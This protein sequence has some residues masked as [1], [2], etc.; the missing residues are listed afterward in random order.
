M[1]GIIGG[2]GL[3]SMES[4]GK[5][6][7][8]RV[9]TEY[10]S[11]SVLAEMIEHENGRFVFLARHGKNHQ[12]APHE[13]NYRANISALKQLGV[14]EIIA[15]NAVG[16][17]T[18]NTI[19]GAIIIPDQLIDYT[20]GR[21]STFFEGDANE[22]HHIDFTHPFDAA[23]SQR[24]LSAVEASNREEH[25]RRMV[26]ARAVYGVTQGP[27]L[28]TAAEINRMKR[29]GCDIVGMTAM[30][31]AALARE[32][33][34]GYAMVALSVNWAAGILPGEISMDEIRGVMEEGQSFLAGVLRRVLDASR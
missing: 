12:I 8:K 9:K 13:V 30:P 21:A 34:I 24:L 14:T 17:I 6:H 7:R 32:L 1:L 31:E 26:L 22:V 5:L 10:D 11:K 15:V 25:P 18:D 27:R 29:D 20:W 2:S 16:G 3:Y 19:P 4:M 33:G 23:L 28:E